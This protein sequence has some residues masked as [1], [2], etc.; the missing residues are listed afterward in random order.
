MKPTGT[1]TRRR[2]RSAATRSII[3]LDTRVLPTAASARHPG[4]SPALVFDRIPGYP[5]GF[6]I[7]SGAANALRRL[8]VGE[9]MKN[10]AAQLV[11]GIGGAL[12]WPLRER[13]RHVRWA[14][15]AALVLIQLAMSK[16]MRAARS[17]KAR[18]P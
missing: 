5:P 16:P 1:S 14:G 8:V 13:M 12:L 10:A 6:R 4:R 2:P 15:V 18:W 17:T 7:L 3:E 9:E 11:L